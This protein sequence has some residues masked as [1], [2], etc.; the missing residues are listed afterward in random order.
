MIQHPSRPCVSRLSFRIST[1]GKEGT[2]IS[3]LTRI[4]CFLFVA[5][6]GTT[7]HAKTLKLGHVCSKDHSYQVPS[8]YFAKRIAE[9]THGTIKVKVYPYISLTEHTNTERLF[10]TSKRFFDSYP[11]EIQAKIMKVGKESTDVNRKRR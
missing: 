9:E 4:F 11:P 2:I 1:N 7:V 5:C 8:D 6:V 10:L 3:W